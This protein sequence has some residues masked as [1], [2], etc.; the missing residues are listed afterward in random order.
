MIRGIS[1]I[2]MFLLMVI[3]VSLVD[4]QAQPTLDSP[5][6]SASKSIESSENNVI[7]ILGLDSTNFPKIKVSIFIDKFCAIAG[8]LK[9][10]N[11]KVK[12]DGNEAAIDNFSFTGK[13][14][15][16]KLDLAV[17]FDDTGSMVDEISAM[18]SKV[19]DLTDTL[20]A[21]GLDANYALVS[22]KDSISVK[23]KWTNDPVAFKKYVDALVADG[24]GDEPEDSIDAIEAVLAMGFRPDAQKVMLVITDAHSHYK[25]DSSVYSSYTKDEIE[26][27]LLKSGAIFIPITPTFD[28]PSA[29][30]DVREVANDLQS[31]WIDIN[32][33]DFSTILEQFKG[34]IT[35]TYVIEYTSPN[36]NSVK[37]R[38]VTVAVNAPGCVVGNASVSYTSPGS[39][40]AANAPPVI[41]NLTP[42]KSSPQDAGTAINWTASATDTDGDEILYR[43]FLNDNPM[44][45]WTAENIWAWASND[46][47]VGSNRVEV[48]VRDG[49][50]AGPNG[51]D[52]RKSVSYTINESVPIITTPITEAHAISWQKTFG[53][54][55]ADQA[56][57]VRQTSDGGYIIAGNSVR[58]GGQGQDAWLIKTDSSGNKQWNRTLRGSDYDWAYSVQQTSDGGDIIAGHG[59]YAWLIKTDSSGNK[60]WDRTLGDLGNDLR[61][62]QQTSDGG[63]IIAGSSST[64]NYDAWLI[65]TDS[66]GNKLWDKTFSRMNSTDGSEEEEWA[67][68]V[69]QT[70]DGGYIIACFT[71]DSA[72]S[73]GQAWLI[74][75]DSSGNKEWDKII[76]GYGSSALSVQQTSNDGYIIGGRVVL[77]STSTGQAWLIKTDSSGN[78]LWDKTFSESDSFGDSNCTADSVQQTSDGGYIIAGSNP[79]YSGAWL[80]KTDSSGNKL[81][82]KKFGRRD[83]SRANEV[84]QTRDNGYI[85]AG[86]NLD[87]HAVL[88]KTDANGN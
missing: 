44:T 58:G 66:S 16:Q 36:Q 1:V 15:A 56:N 18:K 65:K 31:M 43:F 6:N 2:F 78:K 19:K 62:V 77:Q 30:V 25:N 27:D 63:Y 28:K 75:T 39:A 84:H 46:T 70:S 32:S 49:R 11:F 8:N 22:F 50:H 41:N 72:A 34:I 45:D 23:T 24:G 37:N 81:W 26:K 51:L 85:I 82:D 87:R 55:V 21:S 5:A 33:A 59:K 68:S 54:S 64:R 88:V 61:S 7:K 9:K 10:E 73:P 69:Q 48:Q 3:M 14:S 83:L 47:D 35:G 52:D 38:N 74:K 71:T 76:G 57:S 42:D 4:A 17:V 12:E 79:L 86:I 29:Y 40:P 20:K 60:L 13:A 53:G 67:Y 80:I